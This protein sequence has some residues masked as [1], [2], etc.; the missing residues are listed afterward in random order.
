MQKFLKLYM[1]SSITVTVKS[2]EL[3]ACKHA[4]KCTFLHVHHGKNNYN[5]SYTSGCPRFPRCKPNRISDKMP[6]NEKPD[7]TSD[8]LTRTLTFA[9]IGAGPLHSHTLYLSTHCISTYK[10][11]SIILRTLYLYLSFSLYAHSLSLS[12][13]TPLYLSTYHLSIS[14]HTLS[15]SKHTY[16]LSPSLYTHFPSLFLH[17]LP[18]SLHTLSISLHTHS[19]S[20][21]LHTLSISLTTLPFCVS[22][23]SLSLSLSIYLHTLYLY[24]HK[25]SLCLS[26][27]IQV[28]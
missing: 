5:Y 24:T 15:I 4:Q 19:L 16:S 6:E 20:L 22:L 1:F 11:I 28:H 7:K 26:T 2:I 3:Y 14:T 27:T 25:V 23:H 17:S 13:H 10:H 8:S 9:L 21:S 12:L 18:L